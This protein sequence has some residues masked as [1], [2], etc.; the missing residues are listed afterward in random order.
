MKPVWVNKLT[1]RPSLVVHV[2][3]QCAHF[4]VLSI[5]LQWFLAITTQTQRQTRLYI[6]WFTQKELTKRLT[7]LRV[8]CRYTR[9]TGHDT[10]FKW[11]SSEDTAGILCYTL[12]LIQTL[13]AQ[14]D[15]ENGV[16]LYNS[17]FP[18]EVKM[19]FGFM[20]FRALSAALKQNY[21]NSPNMSPIITLFQV[22]YKF[23]KRHLLTIVSN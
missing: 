6:S 1:R 18:G 22:L 17:V 11:N 9:C 23:M 20:S 15:K 10:I 21:H 3:F 13:Y 5:M 2:K 8:Y 12:E 16:D 14:N 7:N 19:C 4:N